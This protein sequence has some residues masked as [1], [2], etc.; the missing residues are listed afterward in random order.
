MNSDFI[1][2]D[3]ESAQGRLNGSYHEELIEISIIDVDGNKLYTHRFKPAKIRKWDTSVHHIT[4]AMVRDEPRVSALLPEIQSIFDRSKYIIGFSLPDD[5][6]AI[7]RAGITGAETKKAVELRHIY[8]YLIG[9]NKG[10]DFYSGPGLSTCANELNV[11]INPEAVHTAYGDALVTL[12]LFKALYNLF[13]EREGLIPDA[14]TDSKTFR[15]QLDLLLKRV[16]EAKYNYDRRKAAGFIHIMAD[17]SGGYR[18]VPLCDKTPRT[19][20]IENGLV[21]I[22]VIAVKARRRAIYELESR[23]AR[24]RAKD[25]RK[26]FHLT[27]AD[28]KNIADYA[29][30]FD[31]QEQLYTKLIGLSRGG[32]Q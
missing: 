2:F 6:K 29:N 32:N 21:S 28:L 17:P 1:C 30:E 20:D 23:Y 4:P 8:W 5:Y 19:I 31:N 13:V 24:R 15:N 27:P 26:I 3:T 12:N 10:I 16:G 14:P 25:N 18:F 7:E 9:N 11:S 22:A